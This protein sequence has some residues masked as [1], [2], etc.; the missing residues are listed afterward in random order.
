MCLGDVRL[1]PWVVGRDV[2]ATLS[3][4]YDQV[5]PANPTRVGLLVSN[6]TSDALMLWL[7]DSQPGGNAGIY[8]S[9]TGSP[10]IPLT[11]HDLGRV[12][13]RPVWM[14]S[15]AGTP[16]VL[17]TEFTTQ[18]AILEYIREMGLRKEGDVRFGR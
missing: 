7:S 14:R 6:P 9:A 15:T 1:M 3:T 10:L 4:T 11:Y 8:L 13:Q 5:L 16:T 18:Q 12:I 17:V 2:V